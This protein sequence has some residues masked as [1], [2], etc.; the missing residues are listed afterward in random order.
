VL[1]LAP[2][3]K[4]ALQ[5]GGFTLQ[6]S[7]GL[8][9]PVDHQASFDKCHYKTGL[10]LTK[11]QSRINFGGSIDENGK[12]LIGII[13]DEYSMMSSLQLFWVHDRLQQ[14]VPMHA[15]C[16]F[17]NV[18]CVF[19]GDPG[20]RPPVGG[21]PLWAPT[22]TNKKA[23]GPLAAKGHALYMNIQTVVALTHVR[24]QS[25]PYRD[26]LG[27]LREGVNTFE[28]WQFLNMN[29]AIDNMDA[30]RRASFQSPDTTFLYTTNEACDQ[31]NHEQLQQLQ[32]PICCVDAEHDCAKSSTKSSEA[33]NRLSSRLYL[34]YDA[35]VILLWNVALQWGLVNGSIGTIVDFIYINGQRAPMLPY[36]VIIDFPDYKGPPFSSGTGREKWVPLRACT[37]D[38]E[39]RDGDHNRK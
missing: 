2:T 26:F 18:P 33:C 3:G 27:R 9:T 30:A 10:A 19:I 34:A 29:C 36:A 7:S 37:F 21:S 38:F 13:V 6:S 14:A 39:D 24:R 22:M 8:C 4:A 12:Q 11:L 1:I 32:Q 35:K 25:G 15:D 31:K 17:G 16:A 5:A 20:Q 23:L 28:D